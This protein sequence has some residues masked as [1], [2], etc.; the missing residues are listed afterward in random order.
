[1]E[2]EERRA[3]K[4]LRSKLKNRKKIKKSIGSGDEAYISKEQDFLEYELSLSMSDDKT[5]SDG[6]QEAINSSKDKKKSKRNSK[7]TNDKQFKDSSCLKMTNE[8]EVLIKNVDNKANA[9]IDASDSV[10]QISS[11]VK[12]RKKLDVLDKYTR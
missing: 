9:S 1:M 7:E 3:E 5:S 11:V 8:N 6:N 10:S 2:I 4:K 12:R